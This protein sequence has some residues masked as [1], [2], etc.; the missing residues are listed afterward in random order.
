MLSIM[1]LARVSHNYSLASG[2][3]EI[4]CDEC[5]LWHQAPRQVQLHEAG[6]LVSY[7]KDR[8]IEVQRA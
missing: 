2:E 7:F 3:R 1:H 8:E 6:A 5:Q 4:E